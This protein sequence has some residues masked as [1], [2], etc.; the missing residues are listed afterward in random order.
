M[1]CEVASIATAAG[2][3][4]GMI[5]WAEMATGRTCAEMATGTKSETRRNRERTG[6]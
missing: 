2:K 3:Q 5:T 4:A 1:P 6:S